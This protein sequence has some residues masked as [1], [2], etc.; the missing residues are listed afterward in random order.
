AAGGEGSPGRRCSSPPGGRR[1]RRHH[2]ERRDHPSPRR[3]HRRPPRPPPPRRPLTPEIRT[4]VAGP[5]LLGSA[6]AGCEERD[7]VSHPHDQLHPP[8]NADAFWSETAW[9]A[10]SV[11][12]RKL[13]GWTYPFF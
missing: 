6:D 13:A 4:G 1:L 9:F 3:R 5:E 12:E 2:G 10:F 7:D 8:T 11:H